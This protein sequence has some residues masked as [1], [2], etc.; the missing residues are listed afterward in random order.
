[1]DKQIAQRKL[2]TEFWEKNKEKCLTITSID[3]VYN[4]FL[5]Y[6]NENKNDYAPLNKYIFRT[7]IRKNGYCNSV[8]KSDLEKV[9][10]KKKEKKEKKKIKKS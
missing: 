4:E 2:A 10:L 5:K 6:Y 3:E 1:M 7:F 8:S 9:A